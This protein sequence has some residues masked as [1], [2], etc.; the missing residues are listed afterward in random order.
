[1]IEGCRE[2]R[3]V[4]DGKSSAARFIG[5]DAGADHA[6]LRVPDVAGDVARFRSS[7]PE[8]PGEAV[9]VAGFPMQGLLTSK[10]S[11]TTGIISALAGPKANSR[12]IG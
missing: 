3:V 10:A 6:I 4:R 11:G 7:D 9:I 5:T 12:S 8:K 1:V 2:L